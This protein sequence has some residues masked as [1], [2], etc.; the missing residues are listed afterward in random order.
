MKS[1][2]NILWVVGLLVWS[3]CFAMGFNYG[4]GDSLLVSVILLFAI[5]A[6]M[7]IDVFFLNKWTN[8]GSGYN[9]KNAKTKEIACLVTYAIM[10][11]LT[12][13]GFAHFVAVQTEVKS[14]VRPKALNRIQEL[15]RVFGDD[16]KGGSY[17]SYVVELA[18]TYR[19]AMKKDYA[20]EG[21]VNLAVSEF[22]DEM[23]G[24]GAYERLKNQ[25]Q[26]FLSDCEQS[27]Q[28]WIPW[29]VT[30]YLTQLDKN[31]E[32]WKVELIRLS[33][34]NEWVKATGES[35][36]PHIDSTVNLAN[37]VTNPSVSDYSFLAIIIIIIL[38]IIVLFPY[39]RGKDWSQSG[40]QKY[41]GKDGGPVVYGRSR[42]SSATANQNNTPEEV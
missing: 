31:T 7:G 9:R 22:E 2:M 4:H 1:F 12:I 11:L 6:I 40:P 25:S 8:P 36:D 37:Q 39:L 3:C 18:A 19:N 42:K 14:E 23:M 33:E 26:K 24:E 21:T 5:L 29:T 41:S 20:D 32:D 34:K 15:R 27:I 13:N 16:N 30:E 38:Q 35:Y 17:Q 10:V 28:F